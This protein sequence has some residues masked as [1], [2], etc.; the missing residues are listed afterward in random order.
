MPDRILY[1]FFFHHVT[2]LESV[3]NQLDAKGKSCKA[4]RSA[5]QTAAKLTDQETATR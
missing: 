1:Q 3:A 5:I 2:N 4:I